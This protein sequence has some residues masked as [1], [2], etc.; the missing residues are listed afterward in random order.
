MSYVQVFVEGL[1]QVVGDGV[2]T[3]DC[4]FEGG[5]LTFAEVN[6][7]NGSHSMARRSDGSTWG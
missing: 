3:E 4:Y 6:A 2:A 5:G 1:P 7:S